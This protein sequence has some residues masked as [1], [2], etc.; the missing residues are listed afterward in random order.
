R[1]DGLEHELQARITVGADGRTAVTRADAA[2]PLIETSPPID[3]L[4]FRVSRR[5]DEAEA[6]AGRI[7]PGRLIVMLNRNEYWQ[8]AF[9]IARG[10]ADAIRARG[11]DE[12]R[13]EVVAVAPE[14]A[15]RVQEIRMWDDVKLLVVRV[16]RLQ[17]WYRRGY[18]A[19]GDAAHAMS[20]IGGVGINVAIQDAVVAANALWLP[21]SQGEVGEDV[22]AGVQQRRQR[23]VRLIQS[24]QT[25][26]QERFL[27]RTLESRRTPSIPWLM[28]V[29]LSTP[30]LRDIPPR[31]IALGFNRPHIESPARDRR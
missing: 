3:V 24:V 16:D 26:V 12:F 2:L 17:R 8:V 10:Q 15:E 28:R 1:R 22:L 4:W 9:V 19:I 30:I 25:F 23:Q 7:G 29:L 21:L 18:L 11:L 13:R 31:L 20:P 27:K 6:V 5:P 14:L